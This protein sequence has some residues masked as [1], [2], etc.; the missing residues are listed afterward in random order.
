VWRADEWLHYNSANGESSIRMSPSMMM[1][2]SVFLQKVARQPRSYSTYGTGFSFHSEDVDEE[3]INILIGTPYSVA[4]F[5]IS[6]GLL[7]AFSQYCFQY[8]I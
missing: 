4:T 5:N 1:Y 8:S 3:R 2:L 6:V 7:N